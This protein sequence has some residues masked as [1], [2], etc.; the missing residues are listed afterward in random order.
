MEQADMLYGGS[1]QII[2]SEG[3]ALQRGQL[4]APSRGVPVGFQKLYPRARGIRFERFAAL[5]TNMTHEHVYGDAA[6]ARSF[7]DYMK[8]KVENASA[9]IL[10][11]TDFISGPTELGVGFLFDAAYTLTIAINDL[12]NQG[13]APE[14]VKGARLVEQIR[15]VAFQGVTGNVSFDDHLDRSAPYELWNA[16]SPNITD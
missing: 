7:L 3:V 10:L 8:V 13:V 12:L 9:P 5:W 16:R 11:S 4:R 6:R 15:H 2:G 14:A 1:Y